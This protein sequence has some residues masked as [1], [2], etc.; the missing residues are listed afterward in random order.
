MKMYHISFHKGVCD[1]ETKNTDTLFEHN[2]AILEDKQYP[3]GKCGN[4]SNNT[5]RPS[6]HK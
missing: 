3:C 4:K 5:Y 6:I 2:Q 1:T